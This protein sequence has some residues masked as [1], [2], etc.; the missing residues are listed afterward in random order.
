M[1]LIHEFCMMSQVSP[2]A[3]TAGYY[4]IGGTTRFSNCASGYRCGGGAVTSTPGESL[5]PIGS[6]YSWATMTS[7]PAGS[8][9]STTGG[10]SQ[11][12]ACSP[13]EAGSVSTNI[14]PPSFTP[15][16]VTPHSKEVI[17]SQPMNQKSL[18]TLC[19]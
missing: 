9:G 19:E 15:P 8:Y 5:C 7:C 12:D 1:A 3:R 11:Q 2:D 13:C 16:P 14:S 10:Q 18:L 17:H 6:Y 4:S